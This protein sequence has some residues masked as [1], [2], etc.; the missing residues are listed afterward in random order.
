[1]GSA[2]RYAPSV[3]QKGEQID[4]GDCGED[5]S[6]RS[7]RDSEVDRNG[8]A[9]DRIWCV[10]L[11]SP[12]T[13]NRTDCF[14]TRPIPALSR[15]SPQRRPS[16]LAHLRSSPATLFYLIAASLDRTCPFP[17]PI[18]SAAF[19]SSRQTTSS[20]LPWFLQQHLPRLLLHP[21]LPLALNGTDAR[22]AFVRDSSA[23]VGSFRIRPFFASSPDSP[24]C[25]FA[26]PSPTK[27]YRPLCWLSSQGDEGVL[28]TLGGGMS[29][30]EKIRRQ[31][32]R[33]VETVRFPSSSSFL[34]AVP[35]YCSSTL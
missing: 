13:W 20:R 29:I 23:Q 33:R 28:A 30:R 34:F 19:T 15:P 21:P 26:V 22:S 35:L 8:A 2:P 11:P 12:R 6:N 1:M 4:R 18:G 16:S 25:T 10:F 17:H 7:R 31:E 9:L 3:S 5:G 32:E 27:R 14:S 24:R